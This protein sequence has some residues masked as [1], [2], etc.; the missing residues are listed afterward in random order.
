MR[1]SAINKSSTTVAGAAFIL[2]TSLF[3]SRFLGLIRDRIL[4]AKFGAGIELDIYFA[5][6]RIPDLIYNI[7][8]GG[9]ISSA[10]IP[11]FI[12]YLKK[13]KEEAWQIASSFLYIAFFGI[14]L[15][16]A[17]MFIFLPQLIDLVVPG[18]NQEYKEIT[19]TMSR[20]MLFSPFL[21]GLSAVFSGILHSLKKFLIYSLAPIFYNVGI[22]IG[23]IFFTDF[24]GIRGLAWGVALGAGLHILIQVPTS[25]ASGFKFSFP[26]KLLHPA[27]R[28]I[29][30]LML[31]RALGLAVLQINLWVVT[32]IASTLAVGSLTIFNLANHIQYLP[33]GIVG[34]PFAMAVFPTLSDSVSERR[35]KD[36]LQEFSKTLRL[37]SYLVIPLSVLFFVLR[38]QIVRIVLGAGE[39]GWEATQLTAASLGAFSIGI[40]AYALIPVLSRAFYAQENTKTPVIANTVGIIIN[41]FLSFSLIY[42]I[43]P[44]GRVLEFLGRILKIS[45]LSSISVIGLPIAFSISGIV[46]LG[47]LIWIFLKDKKNREIF[48]QLSS[49]FFRILFA[50]VVAGFTAWLTLRIF[51]QFSSIDTLPA[52]GLQAGFAAF[53][54]GIVFI[55][56]S[57]I[58]KFDEFKMLLSFI[59]G[60]LRHV[61]ILHET[62]IHT[63][64]DSSPEA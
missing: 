47:L 51:V 33:I 20:I 24:M 27:V 64:D 29:V 50:S 38:A 53:M 6:F 56:I 25:I 61:G 41:I 13:N 28:H 57:Y 54:A 2:S 59:Q 42:V 7:V 10:F 40:F 21:L 46:A 49:A 4:A 23:A 36:Y 55:F 52:I 3:A 45:N 19:V 32:A 14:L 30:K 8:I 35:Y 60:K 63:P 15:V 1:F 31:P 18:F 44:Q 37:V 9:A 17:L 22:I 43:F 11:V 5:G 12:S 39:F 16:C 58:F 62:P 26:R 48:G 34:V